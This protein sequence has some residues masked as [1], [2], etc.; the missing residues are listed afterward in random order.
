VHVARA[1]TQDGIDTGTDRALA[2]SGAATVTIPAGQAV[3][4]DA[5][6]FAVPP[7]SRLAVT[8]HFGAAP[9]GV[10]GHPGSR[11]TS[12]LVT[13]DAV[14]SAKLAGAATTDHWYTIT[15]I[16]VM[17]GAAT[18]AAVVTLGD[19][20]TD[21]RGSTTNGNDRW[22]D[23]LSR[24]LRANPQTANIAVLNQGVGG[25]AVVSGGLGPTALQRFTRDVLDQSGVRWVIVFEGVNDI[26]GPSGGQQA[27]QN[28]IAAYGQLI[29]Q[30]H[31][32]GIRVYG[33]TLTPIGGS[34]YDSA[35][36][37]AARQA[38]NSWI[39]GSGRFDAV[40]D[41]DV[42][43]R[44]PANP[45]TLLATHDTGDHLHL[46]AAGYRRIANAIDL[47]LFDTRH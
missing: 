14:S 47:A 28:L 39:R 6:D 19:S 15:G 44:D 11:T 33:A 2:C 4:S 29:D 20:L 27:A 22:P 12:F 36:H 16:D 43:V 21:G 32:R 41:L 10:T 37:E 38:V 31:A 3:W 7:L 45:T 8:I 40:I 30:A 24:R 42:A 1:T 5:L 26:C 35:D 17:A 34:H 46:S 18:A 13:G 23:N 25:N 9:A